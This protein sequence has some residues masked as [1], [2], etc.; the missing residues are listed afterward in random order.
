MD[1]RE[2][3]DDLRG[4][5]GDRRAGPRPRRLSQPD[6]DHLLRADARRLLRHRHAA[7]VPAL[8]LRQALR[9]RGDDVPQGLPGPGLRDR[10]QLQPLHQLLHGREHHG[11]ADPGPGARRLR[12]QPLLQE[13]LPV[14]AVDRCR[15]DPRLPG[16][17]QGLHR[18]VRGAPRPG[19]R[20]GGPG[21]GPCPDGPGRLPLPPAELHHRA[22][23]PGT[24]RGAPGLRGPD[25]QRPLAHPAQG[26]GQQGPHRDREGCWP[27]ARSS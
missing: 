11:D 5:P 16:V 21:R 14:P 24:R 19:R 2:A 25:L 23:A 26:G 10:D 13:Q 7:D 1:L 9:P 18:Q 6:R 22:P 17:R 12:A 3:R 20:R 27:N 15:G 4:D 8:V